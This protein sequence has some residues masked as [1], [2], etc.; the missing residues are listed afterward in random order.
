[1]LK[2][3]SEELNFIPKKKRNERQSRRNQKFSG[4]HPHFPA[5]TTFWTKFFQNTDVV[6]GFSGNES[7]KILI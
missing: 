7:R 5:E 2:H 1:M 4:Y 6:R 3:S